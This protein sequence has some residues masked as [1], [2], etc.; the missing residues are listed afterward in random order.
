MATKRKKRDCEVKA[1]IIEGLGLDSEPAYQRWKHGPRFKPYWDAFEARFL[2]SHAFQPGKKYEEFDHVNEQIIAGESNMGRIY[3]GR[4][5]ETHFTTSLDWHCWIVF[6][7]TYENTYSFDGCFARQQLSQ[8]ESRRRIWNT[9]KHEM[10]SRSLA[11][12]SVGQ[13]GKRNSGSDFLALSDEEPAGPSPDSPSDDEV[14]S[15]SDDDLDPSAGIADVYW[16]NMPDDAYLS[17]RRPMVRVSGFCGLSETEF[18]IQVYRALQFE[19]N[20]EQIHLLTSRPDY[21]FRELQREASQKS[22]I[23]YKVQTRCIC[24]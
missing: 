22:F 4:G 19:E 3:S 16:T 18:E 17:G 23:R 2:N 14:E 13:R 9:I 8:Y 11:Q 10:R 6:N 24:P 15:D 21:S 7:V 20:L 12:K 1:R 5:A